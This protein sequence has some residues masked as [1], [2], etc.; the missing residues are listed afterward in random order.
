VVG[1]GI[2]GFQQKGPSERR[3]PQKRAGAKGSPK[4]DGLVKEEISLWDIH[5]AIIL[6]RAKTWPLEKSRNF[7]GS[8]HERSETKVL[9]LLASGKL[10]LKGKLVGEVST[11]LDRGDMGAK[12]SGTK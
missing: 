11:D 3:E 8:T 6:R 5:F 10:D 12:K 7:R 9:K 4:K 2:E 1:A